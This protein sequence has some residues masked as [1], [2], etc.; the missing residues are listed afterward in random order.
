MLIASLATLA[1]DQF[2]HEAI[3][4]PASATQ[5]PAWTRWS[6]PLETEEIDRRLEADMRWAEQVLVGG[7]ETFFFFQGRCC[8]LFR[9]AIG[10]EVKQ[11]N[12]NVC[13]YRKF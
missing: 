10:V 2:P 12:G 8:V 3:R 13:K 1:R 9:A 6:D 7:G 4:P 5:A 11:G